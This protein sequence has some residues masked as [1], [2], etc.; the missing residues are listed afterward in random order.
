MGAAGPSTLA[1]A[2]GGATGPTSSSY[3]QTEKWDGTS[4][5]EVSDMATARQAG[6]ASGTAQKEALYAGGSTDGGST[7]VTST[8]EFSGT[9][10]NKKLTTTE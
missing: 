4:W 8:E 7:Q 2:Y 6:S 3:A 5:T 1:L 10:F 9:L